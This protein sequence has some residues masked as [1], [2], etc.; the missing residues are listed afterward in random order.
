MEKG[1]EEAREEEEEVKE[2]E[3]VKVEGEEENLDALL[4]LFNRLLLWPP[5]PSIYRRKGMRENGCKADRQGN[6]TETDRQTDRYPE[7]RTLS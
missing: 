4:I 3:E 6:R 5:N 2:K 1:E 7:N